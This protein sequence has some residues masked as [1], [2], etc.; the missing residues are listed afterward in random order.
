MKKDCI[1]MLLAGGIGARLSEL[2][3]RTAKPALTF[4]GMYRIIDFTLSNCT[5]SG[6]DTVGVLTQYRKES[7]SSYV[8]GGECWGFD[9]EAGGVHFLSPRSEEDRYVGTADAVYKNLAFIR[10][11]EPK[12]VFILSG[13]HIY[14]MDYGRMLSA[15]ILSRADCTVAAAHVSESEAHRFGIIER[16]ADG[17]IVD[18]EE[19][20]SAPKSD[21]ASMGIYVFRT[22]VLTEALEAD[23]ETDSEHDFGRNVIPRLVA[24]EKKV[25]AFDYTG[26]WRDVGTPGTLWA[27]NMDLLGAEPRL[28]LGEGQVPLYSNARVGLPPTVEGRGSVTDAVLSVG[29]VVRG[30][31]SHSVLAPGVVIEDGAE[32]RDCVL[33]ENVRVQ[34]GAKVFSS[35]LG[36]GSVVE[37]G[38]QIGKRGAGESEVVIYAGKEKNSTVG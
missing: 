11:Y 21:L 18:F 10:S 29:D 7:V 14:S 5:G 16:A 9:R 22:E 8:G 20:P 3:A 23:H 26:Y 30:D 27:S 24:E 2:T 17:R 28:H 13:D 4:G 33:M 38:T 25:Y 15:H 34:K 31:V 32:V 36:E 6:I 1:A 37:S 19:K 35:I 12:Y